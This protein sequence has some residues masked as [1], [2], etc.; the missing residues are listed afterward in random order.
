[1]SKKLL[2]KPTNPLSK[3]N[4]QIRKILG[5]VDNLEEHVS[6]DWWRNIFTSLYL[7][8][9][10]DV[11]DD[12]NITRKEID[13]F[14]KILNLSTDHRILDV[15]CGQGRHS[16]E[17]ARRGY[18]Q[19]EGIDRSYYLIQK[20]KEN[21]KKENL[22][23][24][25]KEGDA[26]RLP[27]AP[28]TFDVVM[29][30]GNSFGY[31]ETIQDDLRVLKEICRVMKPWGKLLIDIS[32]G[33]FLTKNYQPRSWEWIDKKLFVCRERAI[34]LDKQRL[35]SRE[36]INHVEK[37]VLADQFYAERLYNQ[38][39]LTHLLESAGFEKC[40]FHS[41]LTPES[42]RNQDLGMM[43][44]RFVVTAS[45]KKEWTPVK[46]KPNTTLKN[47]TVI[48]GDPNKPDQL[49][50]SSVFDE[51]D[52]YTINQLKRALAELNSDFQFNFLTNHDNLFSDLIKLKGKTDLVFNL[53]DEGWN[54]NPTLE[55]H[56]PA[57]LEILNIHYTGAGP[58]S[59]A[60]CYD[61]SLVRGA[62]RE[63]GV[64]VPTGCFIK[65]TDS[66]FE[67]PIDF[68]VIVKPNFGD[69]SIGITEKSVA[70]NFEDLLNAISAIR[71]KLGYDNPILVEEFLEGQEVT[72]GIIGNPSSYYTVLPIIEEDYSGLPDHL[73]KICGYDAKWN[74]NSPYW[75]LKSIKAPLPEE[76]E[77]F[78]TDCSLNMFQR[79][80]CQDYARFD[81]RL[82]R[83]GNP[84][85]LEANPNPGWCWDGHLAKMC[86]IAGITYPDMLKMILQAA[87]QRLGIAKQDAQDK[88]EKQDK[89]ELIKVEV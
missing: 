68:P 21:A 42:S 48:M 47:I 17:L 83:N 15:C 89:K 34:S 62:A 5:P 49:K 38:Q 18:N 53:C 22:T 78:I 36:V 81:W 32:D 11:V 19:V 65:P 54:N 63:I 13:D 61:K 20:A 88:L 70:Y 30:L 4:K 40:L 79:L 46:R 31:F 12:N 77:K 84:K 28:D 64:P 86:K 29:V 8:T 74:P 85:L 56:L 80:Q 87:I 43:E 27:Y 33:D 67:L 69:S 66:I 6:P 71:E 73:P 10:G 59:L 16:L 55:L 51:D 72:I 41:P 14:T 25:F 60:C 9:D 1:M 7:K 2:E 45:A 3:K 82:D 23:I 24:K 39:N 37:G 44:K 50:P 58:Q 76:T 75:H 57:L 52:F 26:R 35:I